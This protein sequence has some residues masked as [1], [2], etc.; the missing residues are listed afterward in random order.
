MRGGQ[1]EVEGEE[2]GRMSSVPW[3]V[4]FRWVEVCASVLRETPKQI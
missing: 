2:G 4:H 3:R 1:E